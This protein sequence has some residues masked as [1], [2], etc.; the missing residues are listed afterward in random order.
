MLPLEFAPGPMTVF[1]GP[2]N[3]GKSLALREVEE[4]LETGGTGDR[5]IVGHM[6]M[7][8][9]GPEDAAAM[10]EARRV[11]GEALPEGWVRVSRL[12]PMSDFV[13]NAPR[14]WSSPRWTSWWTCAR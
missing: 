7:H 5:R 6:E 11:E 1:V 8:F 2:N 10:V 14:T 12:K 9:P 13:R 4:F 3:S